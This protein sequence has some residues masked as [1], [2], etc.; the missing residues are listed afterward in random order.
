MRHAWRGV[1]IVFGAL[2]VMAVISASAWF[3]MK[4]PE[5]VL[6]GEV[7]ATQVQV[8]SKVFGRIDALHVRKGDR[9]RKGQLLATVD[10]P[11]IR[12]KLRQAE[13][14]R[15]AAL[16]QKE[17]AHNGAREEEVRSAMNVWLK[18][19]A[20]SDLAAK[21]CDRVRKLSREG[22]VPAQKLDEAEGQR[23]AAQRAESAARAAY[24]MAMAGARKEDVKAA[25]AL[26]E[27]A[28][29]ALSEVGSYMDE[30][31]LTSPIDG[32]VANIIPER[33]EL[34]SPGCPVAVIL[35]LTD[36]WVTFNVREDLLPGIRVGTVLD[37]RFPAL[38]DRKVGLKVNYIA[39]LG[40][41]AVWRATKASGEFDL[42]TFEVRA[43]PTERLRGLRPGMSAVVNWK[44]AEA[45]S[46]QR[47][48]R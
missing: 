43:V 36:V 12:A 24:E 30:T 44:K 39:N 5:L 28:S 26:V 15:A 31:R 17:K 40:D 10:C 21:T 3:V 7:E 35:D 6:Q 42:K 41:F 9:V 8:A 47:A 22:V 33:G 11:E 16:A 2:F 48:A 1:L 13:A 46:G 32:E 38:G 34:T 25:G 20:A 29:G 4:P 27:Q 19:K 37:A 18:A 23:E 14:A 45:V